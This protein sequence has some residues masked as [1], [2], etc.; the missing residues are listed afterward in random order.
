MKVED[1]AI[2]LRTRSNWEA[3]DLGFA[4]ARQWFL[5]LWGAW[6]IGALPVFIIIISLTH[7]INNEV[8]NTLIFIFFWWLK[9]LYE[10]PL[11]HILSRQL[12]SEPVTLTDI[13][14]NYFQV[15]KPQLSALLLWRRLSLSRSFNNP[16]A[17]LENINGKA[18]RT[19][20]SVLHSQQSS[21]SQWL[22]IICLHLELL[23]YIA[24]LFFI[25]A[26]VPSDLY[27]DFKFIEIF[28]EENLL[29]ITITNIAYFIAISI[30]APFYVAAGFSLYITRRVKLEGWDIELAFKRMKNRLDNNHNGIKHNILVRVCLPFIISLFI[31]SVSPEKSFA[32][33]NFSVTKEYSK[34][35][36][37]NVLELDDFGKTTVEKSWAFIGSEDSKENNTESSNWLENFFEWIFEKI[38]D[39]DVSNGLNILEVIIWVAAAASLIWLIKK[40][41]HWLTWIN[42]RPRKSKKANSI[43]NTIL[44]MNMNVDSL[45]K[46]VLAV[47]SK[48][49]NDK[50]YR[51]ALSLLYRS[52]LSFIVHQGDIEILASATEQECSNLISDKRN[53]DEATFFQALTHA[54]ILLAYAD[55]TPSIETLSVLRDGWAKHYQADTHKVNA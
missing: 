4:L 17:M 40:Y 11:L 10:Q 53:S 49:I 41:S 47:F 3:I 2:T 52:A 34:T 13:R 48:H 16:V 50:Q 8:F 44:G 25:F 26:L 32:D 37:E 20:L 55:H 38:F 22:T 29:F 14:K 18:R 21:A 7:L 12:F 33:D 51:Q 43:P 46:D 27:S 36:I 1:L 9:P 45:P 28:D 24:L 6:L 23:L 54:W 39:G 30:I 15:V 35:T 42:L 31:F 5:R 19:R